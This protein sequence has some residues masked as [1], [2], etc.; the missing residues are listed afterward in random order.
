[1]HTKQQRRESNGTDDWSC[2]SNGDDGVKLGL[3][4]GLIQKGN[5]NSSKIRGPP[6]YDFKSTDEFLKALGL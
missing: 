2:R 5:R 6:V 3:P 4:E 1:M